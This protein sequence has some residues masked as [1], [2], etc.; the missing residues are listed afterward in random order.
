MTENFLLEACVETLDQALLA[1]LCGAHRIELCHDLSAGGLTPPD[2][3]LL[4][5]K[6]ALNLP[7]MVM[8]RP[9]PGNYVYD[10]DGL[11]KMKRTVDFCKKAGVAGVVFGF[12]T[13]DFR[14]DVEKTKA[15]AAYA[16]PLAVTFHKA[17]DD[18]PGPVASLGLL[19]KIP[20]VQRVL[21][22]GG[23]AT[24]LG[25]QSVLRKMLEV[26][27]GG[28]TVVVA[29]KVTKENLSTVHQCIGAKEY[30]GRRIV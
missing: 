28:L 26:A 3:L 5:V 21:T 19:K 10:A 16:A 20:N 27:G 23:A 18:T 7:I 30:H 25:G 29:G 14:V 11:E 1:Q 17:I 24:A 6:R 15:L 8:V 4:A 22:S 12:L 13:P 9:R 2:D